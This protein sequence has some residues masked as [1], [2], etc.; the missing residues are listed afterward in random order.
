MDYSRPLRGGRGGR[1]S[2]KR[3]PQNKQIASSCGAR[4]EDGVV[5]FAVERMRE[6]VHG[7]GLQS[8]TYVSLE[9]RVPQ[10]HPLRAIRRIT[11]RAL[12]QLSPQLQAPHPGLQ[13]PGPDDPRPHAPRRANVGF[14]SVFVRRYST[15]QRLGTAAL[16]AGSRGRHISADLILQ[17][18]EHER[19]WPQLRQRTRDRK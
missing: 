10:D 2:S 8:E 15:V 7:R 4:R 18:V 6:Q 9:D 11:N 17:S 16:V 1:P 5:P 3:L 12:A 19:M 13:P 14:L